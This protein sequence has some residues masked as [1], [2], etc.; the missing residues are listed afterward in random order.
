[1]K[2]L[3]ELKV[4][5][6]VGIARNGSWSVRSEGVYVVAKADK[7]KVVLQ[8][9]SDKYERT[10]S[11]KTGDEKGSTKYRSAFLETVEAQEARNKA[12]AREQEVQTAWR[13]LEAAVAKKDLGEVAKAT[14][15]IKSLQGA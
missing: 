7:V 4:G 8:R 1:M 15:L 5:D 14:A 12:Q 2:N 13:A 10:F 11:A 9:E 3:N 6:K